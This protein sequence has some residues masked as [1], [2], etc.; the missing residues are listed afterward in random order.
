MTWNV[1]NAIL[2]LLLKYSLHNDYFRFQWFLDLINI[3]GKICISIVE[4]N[5][6][7]NSKLKHQTEESSFQNYHS[8]N[9]RIAFRPSF[10]N[11]RRRNELV[12]HK[13]CILTSGDH[14]KQCCGRL[15]YIY[16]NH[17]WI[18][19]L[20][21]PLYEFWAYLLCSRGQYVIV[22]MFS[23]VVY[24]C[25]FVSIWWVK[26]FSTA[27]YSLFIIFITLCWNE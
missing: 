1:Q 15:I 9:I 22:Y 11:T 12:L 4:L 19:T 13:P 20:Y 18:N 7:S 23:A 6:I 5:M 8:S 27:F 2:L 14:V 26:P 24:C 21:V 17:Q 16:Y 25:C 3:W 10:Q